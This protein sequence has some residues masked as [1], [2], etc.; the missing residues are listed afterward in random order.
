RGKKLEVEEPRRSV[1]LLK[2]KMSVT[3][4]YMWKPK[5]TK[6]NVNPN[7]SMPI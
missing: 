6:E 7:V 2:N 5:S 3:A 4:W 1:K